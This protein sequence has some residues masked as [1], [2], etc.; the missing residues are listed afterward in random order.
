MTTEPGV[1][2]KEK[3]D[4]E[5]TLGPISKIF[6]ENLAFLFRL[7]LNFEQILLLISF[8]VSRKLPLSRIDYCLSYYI[9]MNK[10]VN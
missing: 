7:R 8:D 3:K 1:F 4:F 5:M 10:C 9:H 6:D 2:Y